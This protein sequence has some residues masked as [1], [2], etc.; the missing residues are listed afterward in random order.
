MGDLTW[1]PFLFGQLN[2]LLDAMGAM[3]YNIMA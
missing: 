1:S 3:P 2:A